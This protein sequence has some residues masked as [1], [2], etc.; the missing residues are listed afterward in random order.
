V[1]VELEV[2]ADLDLPLPQEA[3]VYFVASE[4]MANV[5]KYADASRAAIRVSRGLDTVIVEI[6][7]D[8][9]GGATIGSGTGLAG[10]HDRVEALDGRFAVNSPPGEGT[11]VRATLPVPLKSPSAQPATGSS[12]PA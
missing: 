3:A 6:A 11:V 10:L 2:E 9:A 8:G 5:A 12:T 7:D 4:A 1:P